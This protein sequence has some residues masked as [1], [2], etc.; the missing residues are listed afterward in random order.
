[1]I[2]EEEHSLREEEF[3]MQFWFLLNPFNNETIEAAI[4]LEFLK[5][6]YDPYSKPTDEIL[7]Q[8]AQ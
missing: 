7:D 5:L 3:L 1:M 6:V 8:I 4:V 2:I